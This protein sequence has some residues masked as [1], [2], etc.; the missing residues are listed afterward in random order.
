MS[1]AFKKSVE[2]AAVAGR[3]FG[4]RF[5]FNIRAPLLRSCRARRQHSRPPTKEECDAQDN[6][7]ENKRF[8]MDCFMEAFKDE[9]AEI[10]RGAGKGTDR[11]KGSRRSGAADEG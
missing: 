1:S 4:F 2:L 7:R 11:R 3:V 6:V 9:I 10:V 5:T 8:M